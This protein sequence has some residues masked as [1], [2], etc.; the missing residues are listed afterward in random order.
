MITVDRAAE[1][2]NEGMLMNRYA[3]DGGGV[4]PD[5]ETIDAFFGTTIYPRRS[6]W[7]TEYEDTGSDNPRV[8]ERQV[9]A[10]IQNIA[11][12]AYKFSP[13]SQAPQSTISTSSLI[14]AITDPAVIR[15]IVDALPIVD[16][17]CPG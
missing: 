8:S 7:V 4:D 10:T 3:K 1:Q 9:P 14:A 5:K 17:E 6:P 16:F 12:I 15:A 13:A 11:D 2:Q